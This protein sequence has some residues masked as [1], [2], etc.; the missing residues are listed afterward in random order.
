MSASANSCLRSNTT[1]TILPPGRSV[2]GILERVQPLGGGLVQ[3]FF[4]SGKSY[5]VD[6]SLYE[7]LTGL[8][9]QTIAIFRYC[10][11]WGTGAMPA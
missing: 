11:H 2:G 1:T 4:A 3:V 10:G 8:I 5:S 7:Q 6:E 9:G